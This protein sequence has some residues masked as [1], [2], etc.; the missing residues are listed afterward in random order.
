LNGSDPTGAIAEWGRAVRG[1]RLR[2]SRLVFEALDRPSEGFAALSDGLRRAGWL[3]EAVEHF[4]NW[5]LPLEGT[6]DTYWA[7]RPAHLRNTV[8]RKERALRRTAQVTIDLFD[9]AGDAERA[10]DAYERVYAAS[11]KDPEP[12]PHFIPA[13]IRSGLAAG[14]VR[15]GIL[16]IDGEPAAGQLWVIWRRRATLFK[17]SY[18]EAFKKQSVGSILTRHMMREAF[19]T[20]GINEVDFGRGDHPYKRDWMPFRRQRWTLTAYNPATACGAAHVMRRYLPRLI[21]R[22][23]LGSSR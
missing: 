19:Q 5:Y 18:A 12:Y 6:F 9:K 3:V 21:R 14:A 20:G 22:R 7:E 17:L 16:S 11:W 15:I 10:I 23:L 4:G 8:E 13:L 1:R 2:P